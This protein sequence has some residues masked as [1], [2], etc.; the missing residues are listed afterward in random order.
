MSQE[1]V[2]IVRGIYGEFSRGNFWAVAALLDREVEWSWAPEHRGLVGGD[3]FRGVEAVGAST[4]E[5]FEAFERY[6]LH[7]EEFMDAGNMVLVMSVGRA[8]SKRGGAEVEHRGGEVWTF[9]DGKIVRMQ[10]F[11]NRHEALEA[12][13]LSE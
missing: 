8:R 6:T 5:F 3:V 11:L 7:S 10:A 9:R 12:A 13:G 4:K 1:N 2:E